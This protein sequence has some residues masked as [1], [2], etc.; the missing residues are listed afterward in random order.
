MHSIGKM[1]ASLR[2]FLPISEIDN[3]HF[4]A[5]DTDLITCPDYVPKQAFWL[6]GQSVVFDNLH[7][8]FGTSNVEAKMM[9][10]HD[11]LRMAGIIITNE[12]VWD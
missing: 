6:L 11:K 10:R 1:L 9:T 8:K 5:T 2:S 7:F 3:N 4:A 12:I